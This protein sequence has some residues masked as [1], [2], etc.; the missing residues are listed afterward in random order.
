MIQVRTGATVDNKP[1]QLHKGDEFNFVNDKSVI[2]DSTRVI[3]KFLKI[4]GCNDLYQRI[5][6]GWGF[7]CS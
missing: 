5:V 4:L 7:N 3:L 2:G 6:K 1:I